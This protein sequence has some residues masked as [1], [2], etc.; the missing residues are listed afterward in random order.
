M[1]WRAGVSPGC[2]VCALSSM[3]GHLC[4][5]ASVAV[6]AAT[7]SAAPGANGRNHAMKQPRP[8]HKAVHA[9][10]GC[11]GCR[12][13]AGAYPMG[14][15]SPWWFVGRCRP[16]AWLPAAKSTPSR[17]LHNSSRYKKVAHGSVRCVSGPGG[18]SSA[19]SAGRLGD[20]IMPSMA[21][22]LGVRRH[23][24]RNT[25]LCRWRVCCVL[26]L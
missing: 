18:P 14:A 8:N 2:A 23:L 15:A 10:L 12:C 13:T 4:A 22:R 17:R 16:A 9:G 3:C 25:G 6:P 7:A 26:C 19:D 5:A 20:C 11:E 24:C 1:P 21:G